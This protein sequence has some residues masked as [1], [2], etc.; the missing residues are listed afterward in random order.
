MRSA[1]KIWFKWLHRQQYTALRKMWQYFQAVGANWEEN[2]RQF[3]KWL[4]VKSMSHQL[5]TVHL[6]EP[7][8]VVHRLN[9]HMT[10]D[11]HFLL[12][13]VDNGFKSEWLRILW[14]IAINSV[15]MWA[16]SIRMCTI[17]LIESFAYKHVNV[18]LVN[19]STLSWIFWLFFDV[20]PPPLKVLQ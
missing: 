2:N 14:K 1:Q 8:L 4:M 18:F 19:R 12:N 10:L 3:F 17:L 5:C 20:K 11:L 6:C 15:C 7:I 13:P 16:Y 9:D